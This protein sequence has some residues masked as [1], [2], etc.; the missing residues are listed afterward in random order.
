MLPP[1]MALHENASPGA[2]CPGEA[3]AA[4][5]AAQA[6][7]PPPPVCPAPQAP[8][9]GARA[10]P[11]VVKPRVPKVVPPRVIQPPP[12]QQVCAPKQMTS[13]PVAPGNDEVRR[14][15]GA[16]KGRL[17]VASSHSDQQ[18][19]VV[20]PVE[21]FTVEHAVAM[22]KELIAVLSNPQLQ[23]T[24]RTALARENTDEGR[25]HVRQELCEPLQSP[26]VQRYGFCA[27]SVGV[28]ESAR[29][30]SQDRIKS[31]LRVEA[32]IRILSSLMNPGAV[33]GQGYVSNPIQK[34]LLQNVAVH[35]N[36]ARASSAAS[37]DSS[38]LES[39]SAATAAP[40]IPP[41]RRRH[42]GRAGAAGQANVGQR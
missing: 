4:M 41:W 15:L 32:K 21:S 23:C 5:P 35:L 9:G 31:D 20:P 39:T 13:T 8:P 7:Q 25:N 10:A 40:E 36:S 3:A 12:P 38:G 14:I 29:A 24:L 1:A 19:I 34:Q 27:G 37:Q 6:S 28:R 18:G 33:A 42:H 2:A 11:V 22:L 26:I 17:E 16:V 30:L